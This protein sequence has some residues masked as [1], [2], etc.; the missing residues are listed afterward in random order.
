MND[1]TILTYNMGIFKLQKVF[2]YFCEIMQVS[3]YGT[4]YSINQKGN[5]CQTVV[6]TVDVNICFCAGVLC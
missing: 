5:G 1:N 2:S 3:Q 4:F 6:V